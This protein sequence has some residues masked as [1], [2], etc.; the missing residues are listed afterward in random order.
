MSMWNHETSQVKWKDGQVDDIGSPMAPKIKAL[1]TFILA[2]AALQKESV[3]QVP[4][5]VVKR[6]H[7]GKMEK[8]SRWAQ[9]SAPLEQTE[10][11][12]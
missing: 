6:N 12:Q 1:Q 3:Q 7:W 5:F 9:Q 4:R 2:T 8:S 11:W 10:A